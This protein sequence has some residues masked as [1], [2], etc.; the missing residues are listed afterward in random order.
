[1]TNLHRRAVMTALAATGLLALSPRSYAHDG[2]HHA[3]ASDGY[4]RSLR[5]VTIPD[6]S[7][8]DADARAVRL[9]ELLAASEPVMLNFIFTS[10]GAI[11]P[12]MS[13]VFSQ[14]AGQLGAEGA[15]LRLVSISIDPENDTPAELKSYGQRFNATDRWRFLTGRVEDVTRIQ[16]AFETYRGDKM[17]HEPLT[18]L[19]AGPG[20]PWVRIEGFASA[21]ALAQEYR[22]AVLQ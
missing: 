17:N 16:R 3:P 12:V 10:C 20:Q 2:A 5:E 15:R 13:Q 6:V 11:C 8:T 4:K 14:V 21:G 19:R 18:F 7:L 9:K 1:M 22:K